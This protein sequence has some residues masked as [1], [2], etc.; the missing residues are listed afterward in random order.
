[1]DAQ[2]HSH[3][4]FASCIRSMEAWRDIVVEQNPGQ[5]GGIA[6]LSRDVFIASPPGC[7]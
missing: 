3:S 5:L 6:F 4:V 1:M 2:L 7:F